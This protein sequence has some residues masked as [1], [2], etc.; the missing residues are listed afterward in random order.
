MKNTVNE[1]R[2]IRDIL[3]EYLGNRK[4]EKVAVEISD[5]MHEE[6]KYT[7]NGEVFY[8]YKNEAGKLVLTMEF[9]LKKNV[10]TILKSYLKE[11]EVNECLE[12][13]ML[14]ISGIVTEFETIRIPASNN[15]IYAELLKH[16][17]ANKK[18]ESFID[19]LK[20]VISK[21]V[22]SFRVFVNDP[23]MDN[24]KLQFASGFRPAVGYSHNELE[25]LAKTK[26]LHLGTK[27]EYI[28]FL[29]WLIHSLINEGWSE[30]NSWKAVCTDSSKLG[31]YK[32]SENA[33]NELEI[34]GSRKVTGKCDLANT[35]KI[36]ARDKESGGFWL[37]G[38]GYN[39]KGSSDPLAEFSL[40][41]DL[42]FHFNRGVGWFVINY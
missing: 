42:D 39:R 6:N 25:E 15:S 22:K 38:G 41:S 17:P 27:D 7:H 21:S 14:E 23:S 18:E 11:D 3:E 34:T 37:A 35:Y 24:D 5:V 2:L 40:Y 13:L 31:H 36:F 10:Q 28:L 12:Q 32:T 26:G 29:G 33:K 16:E 20:K 9:P 19:N 4:A 8:V 30:S 1:V